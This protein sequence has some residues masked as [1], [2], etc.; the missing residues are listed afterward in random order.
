V[1]VGRVLERDR[2]HFSRGPNLGRVTL[3]DRPELGVVVI[4]VKA[5]AHIQQLGDGDLVAIGN[6]RDVLRDWIVRVGY[7]AI[8]A[9]LLNEFLKEHREVKEQ[10][11]KIQAQET[12][13]RELRSKI[14]NLAAM[15]NS[16]HRNCER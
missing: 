5:A 6:A 16:K 9:M 7:T 4:G 8:N 11:C 12:T 10:D 14:G 2:Q 15:V 1:E 3:E 13:I